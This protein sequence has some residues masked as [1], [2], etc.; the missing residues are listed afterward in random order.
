MDI[1]SE[2][3]YQHRRKLLGQ[4]VLFLPIRTSDI[5]S[6]YIRRCARS[7]GVKSI[8]R[9]V[10]VV[11]PA[12]RR[13]KYIYIYTSL[14]LFIW[15][16]YWPSLFGVRLGD[17]YLFIFLSSNVAS[18]AGA[19]K[20]FRSS[21]NPPLSDFRRDG[22]II[23]SVRCERGYEVGCR[24]VRSNRSLAEPLS[25]CRLFAP[26]RPRLRSPRGPN[27]WFGYV[28]ARGDTLAPLGVG[29][30]ERVGTRSCFDEKT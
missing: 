3:I 4:W 2:A 19:S 22:R 13:K 9:P 11:R 6:I 17:F 12:C 27:S 26:D 16:Y 24:K 29:P 5:F 23:L 7:R 14:K 18:I 1:R 15:L 25:R 21:R 30:S 20:I 10:G 28:V 8:G